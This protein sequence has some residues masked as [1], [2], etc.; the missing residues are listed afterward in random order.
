M[1][2]RLILL[3]VTLLAVACAQQD[4]DDA[5]KTGRGGGGGGSQPKPSN[6][7]HRH[8]MLAMAGWADLY[9][10][11]KIVTS[12]ESRIGCM[13]KADNKITWACPISAHGKV[14][15]TGEATLS[16]QNGVITVQSPT[17]G[18]YNYAVRGGRT[19]K[20]FYDFVLTLAPTATGYRFRQQVSFEVPAGNSRN[21]TFYRFGWDLSGT[22]T[23]AGGQWA[24]TGADGTLSI[25]TFAR[26]GSGGKEVQFRMEATE[27][28]AWQGC[29]TL[30]GKFSFSGDKQ[31]L[32]AVVADP[33]KG[34]RAELGGKAYP[35]GE[36]AATDAPVYGLSL[37][38]PFWAQPS[39]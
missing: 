3:T 38:A 32:V 30:A 20:G 28:L 36:C 25:F 19:L 1:I 17:L 14:G 2:P 27:A 4:S 9:S 6:P 15:R 24:I 31:D 34:V 18:L 7:L 23:M 10:L 8:V 11:I 16:R 5:I 26:S 13:S 37:T 29:G 39:P 35:W 22:L 12:D 21:S 33:D